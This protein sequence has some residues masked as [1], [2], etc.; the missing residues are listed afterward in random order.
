M[1]R[2]KLKECFAPRPIGR[3]KHLFSKLLQFFDADDSDRFRD[4]I[5]PLFI[6]IANVLEFIEWHIIFYFVNSCESELSRLYSI[7][8]NGAKG[9]TTLS[10]WFTVSSLLLG[11]HS[12]FQRKK[13]EME[14]CCG[15]LGQ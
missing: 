6:H 9:T 10:F 3:I 12:D 15:R 4:G 8:C 2:D 7:Q 14:R 13:N 1:F 11:S 5:P